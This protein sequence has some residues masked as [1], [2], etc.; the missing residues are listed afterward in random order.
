[1]SF[2][3]PRLT[4]LIRRDLGAKEVVLVDPDQTGDLDEADETLSV[5]LPRGY[6]LE[7]ELADPEADRA[8]LQRR[9]E[10]IV[11]SFWESL[12]DALPPSSRPLVSDALQREL[13]GLV[14]A[15]GAANAVVI[16]AMSS[17]I[18]GEAN[19]PE[20]TPHVD[21]PLA[22]VIPIDPV[23][24]RNTPAAFPRPLSLTERAVESVR[25]LHAMATLPK[26]GLLAHHERE[27]PVPYVAR[28]IATIYVLVLV[29]ESLFDELRAEREVQARLG[30]I[31]RLVVAL[32]P[33]DPTPIGGAKAMRARRPK[34]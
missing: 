13:R 11:S 21:Q 22:E 2:L 9:L 19:A 17:V 8:A 7:V 27:A 10:T 33:L 15:A 23:A 4:E 24:R 29:F 14:E 25:A 16:D 3:P 26:G 6:R 5:A 12:T 28:S 34:S 32:P 1:M 30:V 18:W 31:E 20:A